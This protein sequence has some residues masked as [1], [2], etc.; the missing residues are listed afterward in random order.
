MTP[1]ALVLLPTLTEGPMARAELSFA[2]T[3]GERSREIE[4]LVEAAGSGLR[5][6]L[7]GTYG[8]RVEAGCGGYRCRVVI[9]GLAPAVDAALPL[10][11]G[12]PAMAAPTLTLRQRREARQAWRW[13]WRRPSVVLHAAIQH[14][15]AASPPPPS[16]RPTLHSR[17]LAAG[18]Q[19]AWT[20]DV[21]LV[22]AGVIPDTRS[23]HH[24][25]ISAVAPPP[26][27][28]PAVPTPTPL[29]GPLVLL[30]DSPGATR[31]QL[32]LAWQTD[33][34]GVVRDHALAGDFES[35][36]VQSLREVHTFTYD[37]S[38]ESGDGWAV[39]TWDTR[40]EVAWSSVAFALAELWEQG[41]HDDD[42]ARTAAWRRLRLGRA[43][44]ADTLSGLVAS[45][46]LAEAPPTPN[47]AFSTPAVLGVAV[48]ADETLLTPE[49]A[50]LAPTRIDRCTLLYGDECPPGS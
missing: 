42:G 38:F 14:L 46:S 1:M 5:G 41:R 43:L 50:A 49:W 18:W 21:R 15:V 10:L 26:I 8:L 9:D 6:S 23:I 37:V 40:P 35:R 4:L 7:T 11:L 45:A 17:A 2:R 32:A 47:A 34:A 24:E 3:P 30:V 13:A 12:I 44:L 33:A 19:R 22:V 48:V 20:R 28:T 27:T 25:G 39:A 29:P 36:L 16:P 31:A